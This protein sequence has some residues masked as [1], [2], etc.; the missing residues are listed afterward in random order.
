MLCGPQLASPGC[1]STINGSYWQDTEDSRR[2]HH[3][4]A[5]PRQVTGDRS[6]WYVKKQM[7]Q[8]KALLLTQVTTKQV[9]PSVYHWHRAD[10]GMVLSQ[11]ISNG[12]DSCVVV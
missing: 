5:V 6:Q 12:T 10:A 4:S 1:V 7:R 8:E 3:D 11:E 9:L 2:D